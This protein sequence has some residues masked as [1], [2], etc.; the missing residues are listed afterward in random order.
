MAP[1][2]DIDK[3][4][5]AGSAQGRLPRYGDEGFVRGRG[6]EGAHYVAREGRCHNASPLAPAPSP[7]TV[8]LLSAHLPCH[9]P[10][11]T[12]RAKEMALLLSG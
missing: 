12:Y 9:M 7:P 3:R 10:R 4:G 5:Q 6:V 11:N 1:M 8:L 2:A